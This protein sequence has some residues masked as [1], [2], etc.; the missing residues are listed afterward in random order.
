MR[1][2]GGFAY[3]ELI[4]ATALVGIALLIATSFAAS[5]P[6]AARQARAGRAALEA[7]ENAIENVRADTA[8]L[9]AAST[10][11]SRSSGVEIRVETRPANV[12]GLHHVIAEARYR[13]DGKAVRRR[14]E[15]LVWRPQ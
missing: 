3:A 11:T 1:R 9:L 15:T 2:P 14:L 13:V 5:A 8:P 10:V 7:L 4:A 6:R 12:P